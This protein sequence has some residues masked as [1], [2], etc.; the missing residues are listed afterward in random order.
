MNELQLVTMWARAA[1]TIVKGEKERDEQGY[2]V[3]VMIL[4]AVLA[5]AAIT[6]GAIVAAKIVSKANSIPTD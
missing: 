4:I 3:E 1:L 6:A 2:S 5:A